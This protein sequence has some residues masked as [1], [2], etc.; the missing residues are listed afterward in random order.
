VRLF[1]EQEPLNDAARP[2]ETPR[3]H[4]IG[5][6]SLSARAAIR[7]RLRSGG[8][9]NERAAARFPPGSPPAKSLAGR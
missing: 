8:T 2:L 6:T 4:P 3:S 7:S 1:R 9:E 5:G